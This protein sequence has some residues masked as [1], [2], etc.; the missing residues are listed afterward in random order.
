MFTVLHRFVSVTPGTLEQLVPSFPY[1]G[2]TLAPDGNFYGTLF[3][4]DV[5]RISPSGAY[6]LVHQFLPPSGA[7]ILIAALVPGTDGYLYDTWP[8]ALFPYGG[9]VIFRVDPTGDAEVLH[10][11]PYYCHGA[12][13]GTRCMPEG[14]SPQGELAVGPGSELYGANS[15]GGPSLSDR[16]TIVR[17][18]PD[19]R[20][21]VMREFSPGADATYADG[22]SPTAGLILGSD[23]FVY[24]TTAAGGANGNGTIFRMALEGAFTTLHSFEADAGAPTKGRL[25]E[26]APGVL[27]GTAPGPSGGVVYRLTV[28]G[29][30]PESLQ[31][32][33]DENQPVESV[34]KPSGDGPSRTFALATDGALGVATILDATTGAFRYTP[35]PGAYGVDRFTVTATDGARES[36]VVVTVTIQP[37]NAPVA[38]TAAIWTMA[39]TAVQGLLSR[40]DVDATRVFFVLTEPAK[41]TVQLDNFTGRF[42]Y[43]PNVGAVGIDAFTFRIYDSYTGPF[44]V[45]ELATIYVAIASRPLP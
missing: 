37:M 27:Y 38:R 42:T 32:R 18:T 33:T 35:N 23:G 3:S 28:T 25:F 39:N 5:F 40:S 8:N 2:L 24:G 13:P 6:A 45:S 26:A 4:G 17:L 29:D 10:T 36:L 44:R 43:T 19:R 11:F 20:L 16:G 21:A 34:L 41:G 22:A 12:P 31:F 9:D 1:A 15:R 30:L 7:E 14:T